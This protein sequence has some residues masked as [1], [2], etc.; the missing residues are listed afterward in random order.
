MKRI[1]FAILTL[2]SL[3]PLSAHAHGVFYESYKAEA[4]VIHAEF[5]ANSPARFA[6]LEIYKGDSALPMQEA[7]MDESGNFAFLPPED[8]TY[9]VLISAGSDHG[10]HT[11]DFT[12]DANA[13]AS[14][15]T[16]E[17]QPF[18]KYIGIL[19]SL[20][21]IFGLFGILAL[22]KSRRKE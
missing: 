8:G 15:V 12:I 17:K 16:F 6:K 1:F 9:R 2:F 20:G 5:A 3:V 7:R 14:E 21:V 11:A 4:I 13:M 19:G 18:E 22:L 10:E